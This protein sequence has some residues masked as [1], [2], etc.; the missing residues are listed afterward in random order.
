MSLELNLGPIAFGLVLDLAG[1]CLSGRDGLMYDTR[2]P[3]G[4]M[5]AFGTAIFKATALFMT[6]ASSWA[7]YLYG[8]DA[9]ISSYK[10]VTFAF[11][12]LAR[13]F[14]AVFWAVVLSQPNAL[15]P[16]LTI[17]DKKKLW[18][19]QRELFIAALVMS[20][21]V[22]LFVILGLIFYIVEGAVFPILVQSIVALWYLFVV[23]FCG[24]SIQ[25]TTTMAERWH[26]LIQNTGP[27][28]GQDSSSSSDED[29]EDADGGH[30]DGEIHRVR[31][32]VS[33]PPPPTEQR[34]IVN[35]RP[36]VR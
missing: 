1:I 18:A 5:R 22:I 35:T 30:D 34:R 23:I 13:V 27:K 12:I 10:D 28:D 20:L 19:R 33:P 2:V 6:A 31:L 15:D 36:V 11:F 17:D 14:S 8:S 32:I 25:L 29:V 26:D 7:Q 24:R 16:K 21:F 9:A 3:R 4:P